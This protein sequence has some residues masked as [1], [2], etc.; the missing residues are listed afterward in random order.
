MSIRLLSYR[1]DFSPGPADSAMWKQ[2]V[3][4]FDI[5]SV[6]FIDDQTAVFDLD[7]VVVF[8][9][10]GEIPLSEFTH[11]EDGTYL[12]GCTGMQNIPA[13]Y[14]DRPSVRIEVPNMVHNQGLFGAQAA[15]IV[16]YDRERKSWQ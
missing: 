14:P 12:F 15:A 3:Q 4:A 8:D 10:T 2:L 7:T 9:E 11:P 5:E 13:D 6:Q 16:L 1:D